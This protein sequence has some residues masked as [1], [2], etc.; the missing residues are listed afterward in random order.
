MRREGECTYYSCLPVFWQL[1]PKEPSAAQQAQNSQFFL[2]P[3]LFRELC[4]AAPISPKQAGEML[5]VAPQPLEDRFVFLQRQLEY[6]N[7]LS[8]ST[9]CLSIPFLD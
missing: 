4:A 9:P 5:L 8:L 3:P 7:K 2:L 1:L 6:N